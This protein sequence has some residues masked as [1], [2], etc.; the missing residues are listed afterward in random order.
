MA[1]KEVEGQQLAHSRGASVFVAGNCCGGIL[2]KQQEER[3]WWLQ[4]KTF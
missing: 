4:Q 3:V 2:Y 1:G